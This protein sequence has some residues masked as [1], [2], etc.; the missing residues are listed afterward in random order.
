MD[1]VVV[2][3]EIQNKVEETPGGWEATDTLG[4]A[5]AVLY[6]YQ[7]DRFRVYGPQ[8]VPALQDRLLR[9]DRISGY[10]I[11]A[12]DFPVIW[13]LPGRARVASLRA[14][15]DD[16]LRR[17]WQAIELNPDRFS[18][19][20]KGWGLDAIA[21]ATLGVGKIGYGGDAPKWYQQGQHARLINYCVDDVTL[22]RDLTS[23]VDRWGFVLNGS[24]VVRIPPW[25]PWPDAS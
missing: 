19:R 12:F 13:G 8:D 15:T 17:I 1:H 24:Q 18:D 5:C 16:L 4:V 21:T 20:H 9:A 14:K 7:I 6:E 2:D 11:W 22:E 25:V 10:N 3:V 23:F